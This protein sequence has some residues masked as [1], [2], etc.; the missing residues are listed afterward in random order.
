MNGPPPDDPEEDVLAGGEDAYSALRD[1]TVLLLFAIVLAT[2]VAMVAGFGGTGA[3]AGNESNEPTFPILDLGDEG[4]STDVVELR[5]AVN[6][7]SVRPGDAVAMTVT[8]VDGTPVPNASVRVGGRTHVTDENGTVVVRFDGGEH[9]VSATASANGTQFVD[10]RRTVVVERYVTDLTLRANATNVTAGDAVRFAVTDGE[11]GVPA[12]VSVAGSRHATN[13]SGVAVVTLDRA[14]EFTAA[15]HKADTPSRR[16]NGSSVTVSVTRR[17]ATLSVAVESS[18]PVAHE[19]VPVRVTRDDTGGPADATVTVDGEQYRTDEDGRVN[20]T[21]DAVGDLPLTATAADTPAVTF[22][23]AERTL[24]V[25]RRPVSLSLSANRTTV[26]EGE[27]V[28]FVLTRTDTGASV[29][30]T[31]TVNGTEYR[32]DANGTVAATFT[33]PGRVI[34]RGAREDSATETFGT[35]SEIVTV[36][37]PAY[38]LSSFEAPTAAE[39]GEN[40][41]A[42]VTVT[43]DGNEPGDGTV[44]YRFDG[45]VLDERRVALDPD[46]STTVTFEAAIPA[47][48]EPG[49]Y[50]QATV[51]ADGTLDEPI[52]VTNGNETSA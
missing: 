36:R 39:A 17:T 28:Q 48:A 10:A 33:E 45:T 52:T 25:S 1:P 16:F 47:D 7:S 20:V 50:R 22:R 23:P 6:Q 31:V 15:A 18:D 46:E 14:G 40:V 12:T 38:S 13:E 51:T 42:T 2:L 29:D 37:G 44:E 35:A 3:L 9:V 4:P 21:A 11:E 8:R 32:T 30:G 34:V 5:V 43:N 49:D 41:T 19:P 24:S 26:P 27:A